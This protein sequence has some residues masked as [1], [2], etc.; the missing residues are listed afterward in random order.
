MSS[1]TH[2]APVGC[3][4]IHLFNKRGSEKLR[5]REGRS[6]ELPS[7]PSGSCSTCLWVT[8]WPN[9]FTFVRAWGCVCLF[10]CS[11]IYKEPH[12]QRQ[13]LLDWVQQAMI[14]GGW[15]RPVGSVMEVGGVATPFKHRHSYFVFTL[16]A[17]TLLCV[18]LSQFFHS[19]PDNLWFFNVKL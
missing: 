6:V 15:V 1:P 2:S 10:N 9:V 19:V 5:K 14:Q 13:T 3:L 17:W 11:V 16:C 7:V 4:F 18:G 8:E 12:R